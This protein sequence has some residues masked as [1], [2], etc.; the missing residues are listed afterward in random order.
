MNSLR[1]WIERPQ[2]IWLRRALFQIHLWTGIGL[3]LYLLV[4]CITGSA[5][6]FRWELEAWAAPAP[7]SEPSAPPL[8]FE[9]L[10]LVAEKNHPGYQAVGFLKPKDSRSAVPVWLEKDEQPIGRFLDPASGEDLGEQKIEGLLGWLAELH[11]NLLAGDTGLIVNGVGAGC[12]VVMCITGAVVWW[13]GR[14]NWRRSLGVR[15]NAKWKRLNWDLHS[16]VGIWTLALTLVWAV[17][18]VYFSFPEPF[19]Q[20]FSVF[21]PTEPPRPA[22]PSPPAVPG[23]KFASLDALIEAAEKVTPGAVTTWIEAPHDLAQTQ[24]IRHEFYEP[25]AAHS[26]RVYLDAYTAKVQHMDIALQGNPGDAIQ[27][28]FGYLHFGNFGGAPAKILWVLLGLAP[29]ALGV[30]GTLMWWNRLAGKRYQRWRRRGLRPQ[31]G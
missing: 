28:W 27:R 8:G 4:V 12:L 11:T 10:K 5:L 18:G 26:P 24:I 7:T 31:A 16:A 15:W 21:T 9:A 13:P 17:T 20:A 25:W 22:P 14:K 3:G 19:Q 30:T 6:V 1:E 2:R 23:K 29:A